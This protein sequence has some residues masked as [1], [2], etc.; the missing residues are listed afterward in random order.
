LFFVLDHTAMTQQQQQQRSSLAPKG[1]DDLAT[2][3]PKGTI[4]WRQQY[5]NLL[6]TTLS[7]SLSL[8]LA[9]HFLC[10]HGILAS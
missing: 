2:Y 3:H 1:S 8:S 7:L 6:F 4:P 10:S 9:V 5:A